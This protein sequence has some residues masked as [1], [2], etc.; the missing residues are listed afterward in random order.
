MIFILSLC[1]I[2]LGLSNFYGNTTYSIPENS[3]I[4][5]IFYPETDKYNDEPVLSS[6]GFLLAYAEGI[7]MRE[8]NIMFH[9]I[10]SSPYIRCIQTALMVALAMGVEKIHINLTLG[11]KLHNSLSSSEKNLKNLNFYK[12][13]P[14]ENNV[15]TYHKIDIISDGKPVAKIKD[16]NV[17][18]DKLVLKERR[19]NVLFVGHNTA[20][21]NYPDGFYG[22]S[23]YAY[24]YGAMNKNLSALFSLRFLFLQ[25]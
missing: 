25:Y 20:E 22:F 7:R 1:V 10:E 8:A 6:L 24:I 3:K 2:L 18:F 15:L 16:K 4:Y 13:S 21:V 12:V 9:R 19:E 5:S 11:E 14:N 17:I 23:S